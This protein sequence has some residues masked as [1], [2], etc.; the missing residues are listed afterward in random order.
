MEIRSNDISTSERSDQE[1]P[2]SEE[3]L[4]VFQ[5][6]KPLHCLVAGQG[7]GGG[8]S[9]HLR[10]MFCLWYQFFCLLQMSVMW[11]WQSAKYSSQMGVGTGSPAPSWSHCCWLQYSWITQYRLGQLQQAGTVTSP[12]LG[13]K[14]LVPHFPSKSSVSHL[15]HLGYMLPAGKRGAVWRRLSTNYT[16]HWQESRNCCMSFEEQSYSSKRSGQ[17]ERNAFNTRCINGNSRLGYVSKAMLPFCCLSWKTVN[18][19]GTAL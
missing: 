10:A 2:S 9:W 12:F 19:L 17:N 7:P 14:V 6:S 4:K 8:V 16:C 11:H 1:G 15:S 18:S 13:N 5:F 3:D